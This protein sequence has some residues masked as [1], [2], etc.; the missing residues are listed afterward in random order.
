MLGAGSSRVAPVC[1]ALLRI[2]PHPQPWRVLLWMMTE[3]GILC[4]DMVE[5]LGGA[6]A[7]SNLSGGAVP[8]WAGVLLTGMGAFL[9]LLLERY[10]MRCLEALLMS[11]VAL[12]AGTF[13]YL[14]FSTGVDYGAT[15][16]SRPRILP[17]W[18]RRL[19]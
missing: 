17:V 3:L 13:F 7:I 15:F 10:G 8:L 1:D 4:C 2:L 12:M 18:R 6:V 11:L 5:V 9:A 16:K 14:F 19:H